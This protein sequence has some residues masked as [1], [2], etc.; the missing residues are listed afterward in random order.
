MQL[1]RRSTQFIAMA[2]LGVSYSAHADSWNCSHDDLVREVQIEY[3]EGGSVP[4]NV[5][6]KKQTEGFEDQVLWSAES[7]EGYCEEKAR[8]FVGKLE[9]WG[10]VCLE[11]VSAAAEPEQAEEAVEEAMEETEEAV[12]EAV[13]ET[14]EAM[15]E[16][17]ESEK[18][19]DTQ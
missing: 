1:I 3:P 10:W 8:E 18:A 6:Y 9:S 13:E 15:E 17:V 2:I 19:T 5:I 12:E 14:E 4:C 16:A 11:T 7:E